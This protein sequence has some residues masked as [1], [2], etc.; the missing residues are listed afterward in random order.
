MWPIFDTDAG[1]VSPLDREG[2]VSLLA[3][4]GM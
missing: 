2:L 4:R 1:I 3:L